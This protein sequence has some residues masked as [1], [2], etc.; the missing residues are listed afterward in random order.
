MMSVGRLDF[1]HSLVFPDTGHLSN[2]KG[3]LLRTSKL[4]S[5]DASPG[6]NP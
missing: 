5:S 2:A 6:Y 4:K 3:G 1:W